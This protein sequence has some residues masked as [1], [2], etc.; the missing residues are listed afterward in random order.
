[1]AF[2][3]R[4][5]VFHHTF[6]LCV[7]TLGAVIRFP[8][9]F[10]NVHQFIGQDDLFGMMNSRPLLDCTLVP[11]AWHTLNTLIPRSLASERGVEAQ[12][13]WAE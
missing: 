5:N 12:R 9:E 13:V 3:V 4:E 11:G 6:D 1:M 2:G 10:T 8:E 7:V